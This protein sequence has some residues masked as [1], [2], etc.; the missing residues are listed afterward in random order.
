MLPGWRISTPNRIRR[1]VPAG[2][3][4]GVEVARAQ[5]AALLPPGG[6]VVFTSGATEALNW[7]IKGTQGAIVTLATEHAA[8]LDTVR[9]S[10]RSASVQGVGEDGLVAATDV[11]AEGGWSRRAGHTETQSDSA[12]RGDCRSRACSRMPGRR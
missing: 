9:A 11:S 6:R 8:V 5:V 7:A 12:D 2:R 1:I 4:S 10:G 3:Q